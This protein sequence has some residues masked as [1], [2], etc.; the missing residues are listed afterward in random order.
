[1]SS[2]KKIRDEESLDFALQK[3]MCLRTVHFSPRLQNSKRTEAKVNVSLQ[4]II[5]L[6][7]QLSLPTRLENHALAS[8]ENVDGTLGICLSGWRV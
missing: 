8:K 2:P 4:I 7:V 3:K 1:M 5:D 6:R